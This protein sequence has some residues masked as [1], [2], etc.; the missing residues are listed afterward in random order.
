MADRINARL[1]EAWAVAE[2][3]ASC[4]RC[5]SLLIAI[6]APVAAD[7]A[8]IGDLLMCPTVTPSLLKASRLCETTARA[9]ECR[10]GF[11]T[12]G[13]GASMSRWNRVPLSCLGLH[14]L[15][16]KVMT[17]VVVRDF[18]SRLPEELPAQ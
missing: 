9:V 18:S 7:M 4:V 14:V 11:A 8:G 17:N 13:G 15:L 6:A 2:S 12:R 16:E 5:A 10:D 3:A 1:P